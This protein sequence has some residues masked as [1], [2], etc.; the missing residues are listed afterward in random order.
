MQISVYVKPGSSR[1]QVGGS[2]D[3]RLV[4]AVTAAAVDGAANSA[5]VAALSDALNT[6]KRNI[7]IKSG[8]TGKRKIVEV[9][10]DFQEVISQLLKEH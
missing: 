8:L 3:E 7:R 2:H 10:G 6:P 9:D 1:N 4:V 5:V